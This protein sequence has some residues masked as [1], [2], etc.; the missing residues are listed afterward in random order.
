M[1]KVLQAVFI[2]EEMYTYR[3]S[4]VFLLQEYEPS[5]FEARET[6]WSCCDANS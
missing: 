5:Y 1:H 6:P 2:Q 4:S 3:F